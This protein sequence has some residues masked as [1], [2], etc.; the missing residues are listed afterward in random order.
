MDLHAILLTSWGRLLEL[1]ETAECVRQNYQAATAA[2]IMKTDDEY[3]HER[4]LFFKRKHGYTKQSQSV[5]RLGVVTKDMKAHALAIYRAWEAMATLQVEY[6]ALIEAE[7]ARADAAAER[8]IVSEKRMNLKERMAAE[9][10]AITA[11]KLAKKGIDLGGVGSAQ[12]QA[13]ALE[14]EKEEKKSQ[15]AQAKEDAEQKEEERMSAIRTHIL[16]TYNIEQGTK[17]LK[18]VK[19]LRSRE[20]EAFLKTV[21]NEKF[22][23]KAPP[24][25]PPVVQRATPLNTPFVVPPAQQSVL[26]SLLDHD[27]YD[28][29]S[30]QKIRKRSKNSQLSGSDSESDVSV[31]PPPDSPRK[32]QRMNDLSSDMQ[33]ISLAKDA[34]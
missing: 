29:P 15:K 24:P 14:D 6:E 19:H 30:V 33:C 2:C 25:P 32:V 31:H 11:E 9:N 3:L 10:R 4:A 18:A 34:G 28:E 20:A 27:N 7:K 17:L 1:L 13:D 26:N 12:D 5:V 23:K 21:Y 16:T 8:D 22:P